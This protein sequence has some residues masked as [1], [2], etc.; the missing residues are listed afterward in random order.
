[1]MDV[2]ARTV[3]RIE[4]ERLGRLDELYV[5]HFPGALGLAY[6][7]TGE[8]DQ[9]EDLA[10]EAFLRLSGRFGTSA[11]PR[12]S[13]PISGRRWSTSTCRRCAGAG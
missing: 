12:L 6:L 2:D 13:A 5:Q 11:T 10:Q 8:R 7:L 9:A 3:T 4:E 1:M